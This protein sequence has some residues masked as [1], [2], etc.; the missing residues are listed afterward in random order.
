M[1]DAGGRFNAPSVDQYVES[2]LDEEWFARGWELNED[3]ALQ[4]FSLSPFYDKTC[5]NERAAQLGIDLDAARRSMQGFE[6]RV[7]RAAEPAPN[8][9]L[10]EKWLWNGTPVPELRAMYHILDR[11]IYQAPD[12]GAILAAR[13]RRASYFLR[14][15]LRAA[16]EG[17]DRSDGAMRWK[18]DG[19]SSSS[20][21]SSPSA[22]A[23]P[24]K[25]TDPAVDRRSEALAASSALA[26]MEQLC[27]PYRSALALLLTQ[28]A[29][30]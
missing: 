4:Y 21:S 30:P 7:G 29:P 15:A 10:I 2:H 17:I 26:A 20:L 12:L 3:T 6:Y 9:I 1:D 8:L 11:V 22:G 23:T 14:E 5:I 16:E 27:T 18:R 28:Q 19:S 25:A 24:A 13:F